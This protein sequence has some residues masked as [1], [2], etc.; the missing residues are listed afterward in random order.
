MQ[1][2]FKDP[3][4]QMEFPK[5]KKGSGLRKKERKSTPKILKHKK[6]KNLCQWNKYKH[7]KTLGSAGRGLLKPL[8]LFEF[9]KIKFKKYQ[10]A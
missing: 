10:A 3:L 5:C 2:S 6:R 1:S 9:D 8:A 4:Q 7:L